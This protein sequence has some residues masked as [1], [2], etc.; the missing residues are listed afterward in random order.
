MMVNFT[1]KTYLWINLLMT[2]QKPL[3]AIYGLP[4]F[5]FSRTMLESNSEE[6]NCKM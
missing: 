1:G 4:L 3:Q 6:L 5:M 2:A